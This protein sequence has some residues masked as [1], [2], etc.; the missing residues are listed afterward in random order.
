MGTDIGAI[1]PWEKVWQRLQE[2]ILKGDPGKTRSITLATRASPANP[3]CIPKGQSSQGD[4]DVTGGKN[5]MQMGRLGE[6]G[7]RLGS[8]NT[9]YQ[10][11]KEDSALD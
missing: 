1:L 7:R 11:D 5:W 4:V 2:T 6:A 9:L 10:A 8:K 3:E